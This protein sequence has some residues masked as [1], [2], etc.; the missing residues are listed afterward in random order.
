MPALI[1]INKLN[2]LAKFLILGVI[3]I[4]IAINQGVLLQIK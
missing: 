2:I 3:F 1:S 4:V